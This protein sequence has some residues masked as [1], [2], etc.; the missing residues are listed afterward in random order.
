MSDRKPAKSAAA[1][2]GSKITTPVR[3]SVPADNASAASSA[4]DFLTRACVARSVSMN[5]GCGA[6]S[7][8]NQKNLPMAFIFLIVTGA[9]MGELAQALSNGEPVPDFC[10]EPDRI[11]AL[12]TNRSYQG[13]TFLCSGSVPVHGHANNGV[14]CRLNAGSTIANVCAG[15][16]PPVSKPTTINSKSSPPFYHRLH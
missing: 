16:H 4:A 13:R 11:V 3:P 1:G 14:Y 10:D 5:P 15:M 12:S 2:A 7:S 8:P 6:T 9:V